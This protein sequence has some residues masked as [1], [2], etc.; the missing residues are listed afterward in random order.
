MSEL[1]YAIAY[2]IHHGYEFLCGLETCCCGEKVIP[3]FS[4]L[5]STAFPLSY[6]QAVRLQK[7]IQQDC[8]AICFIVV[9]YPRKDNLNQEVS[10]DE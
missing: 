8:D 6:D 7:C 10:G 2:R 3:Y 9:D 1:K 4:R 5:S